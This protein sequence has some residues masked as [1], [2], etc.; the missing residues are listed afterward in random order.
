MDLWR[1]LFPILLG[2][3]AKCLK[4]CRVDV[5]QCDIFFD[6]VDL[7]LIKVFSFMEL[8]SVASIQATDSMTLLTGRIVWREL[9]V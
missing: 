8:F 7:V 5:L 3:V 2:L 6:K 4:R 1:L 9:L